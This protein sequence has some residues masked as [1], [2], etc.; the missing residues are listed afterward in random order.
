MIPERPMVPRYGEWSLS[1]LA[2]SVLAALGVPGF[3]NTLGIEPLPGVCLL[4]VDEMGSELIRAF[5]DHAP[6]L[7]GAADD[8]RPLTAGFPATTSHFSVVSRT[9]HFSF[10]P[11][12]K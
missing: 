2:P 8:A 10:S 1:D 3:V 4:V 7:A 9:V 12:E 6:F 11:R 5:P